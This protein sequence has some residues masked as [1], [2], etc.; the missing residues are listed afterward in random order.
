M[1]L[2]VISKEKYETL[3]NFTKINRYKIIFN[4]NNKNTTNISNNI[5]LTHNLSSLILPTNNIS[6]ISLSS[7]K[8]TFFTLKKRNT[9]FHNN[10]SLKNINNSNY[11]STIF[12]NSI[13]F[14]NNTHKYIS[15]LSI[16]KDNNSFDNNNIISF[17]KNDSQYKTQNFLKKSINLNKNISEDKILDSDKRRTNINFIIRNIKNIKKFKSKRLLNNIDKIIT[18][19]KINNI[20]SKLLR[21]Q[22]ISFENQNIIFNEKIKNTLLSKKYINSQI[23]KHRHFTFGK[24]DNDI[25]KL[26]KYRIN[27]DDSNDDNNKYIPKD[28]IKLLNEKDIKIIFSDIPYF[29]EVSRDIVN[30]LLNIK[31]CPLKE[32]LNE[33]E[34]IK[35]ENILNNKEKL[36]SIPKEVKEKEKEKEKDKDKD[37]EKKKENKRIKYKLSYLRY[38][39]KTLNYEKYINKLINDDLTHR[40]KNINKKKSIDENNINICDLKARLINGKKYFEPDEQCEDACYKSFFILMDDDMKKQFFIENNNRR[41]C[42]EDFFQYNRRE[43]LKKEEEAHN[44]IVNNLNYLKKIHFKFKESLRIIF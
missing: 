9:K 12:N 20:I 39:D 25:N 26:N 2:P 41:L 30:V 1:S 31:S 23:K 36:L 18:K 15:S 29:K 3:K 40:I 37:K 33:E 21:N 22:C 27:I 16:S 6:K 34:G 8:N 4:K 13:K 38:N 42:R 11:N 28:V 10:S 44:I 24:N 14:K 43:K 7:S 35:I 19:Y 32:T 17:K 5:K